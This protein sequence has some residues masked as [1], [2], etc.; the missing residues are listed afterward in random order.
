MDDATCKKIL[1]QREEWVTSGRL[2]FL[3]RR[4]AELVIARLR[5]KHRDNADFVLELVRTAVVGW[6]SVDEAALYAGGGDQPVQ[7]DTE[8]F[9]AW[10]EDQPEVYGE[11]AAGVLNAIQAHKA[12]QAAAEKN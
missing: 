3:V 8:T 11:I 12:R 1:A 9:I 6:D 5:A 4:P 2:R 7:F 10:V